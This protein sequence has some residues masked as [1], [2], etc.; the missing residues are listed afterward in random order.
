MGTWLLL[1][2]VAHLDIIHVLLVFVGMQNAR[3]TESWRFPPR[4]Q[5][6]AFEAR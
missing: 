4:F 5:R 1:K 2:L 6:K 3:V